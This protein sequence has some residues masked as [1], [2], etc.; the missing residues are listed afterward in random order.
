MDS[1][2]A[3]LIAFFIV[4]VSPRPANVAVATIAMSQGRANGIKFGLGL[5]LGLAIW[6]IVAASGLGAVLQASEYALLCLKI[7]G[8][9]YLIWL[10]VQ[11]ARSA[12][13]SDQTNAK[14]KNHKNWF[15]QGLIMNISNPKAVIAW[16]AALSMG[17]GMKG[18]CMGLGVV[19]Y[20]GHAT[21]FSFPKVMSGYQKFRSWV[22]GVAAG[23]FAMAGFGLIKSALNR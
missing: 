17:L 7:A 19:N 12:F 9:L 6:G 13:H 21:L 5:S 1:M 2:A 4:T 3:I 20:I 18:I 11:S 8:G 22:E 16:M 23:L 14:V 10:S 15:F